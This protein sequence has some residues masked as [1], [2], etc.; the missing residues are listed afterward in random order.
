MQEHGARFIFNMK[1]KNPAELKHIVHKAMYSVDKKATAEMISKRANSVAYQKHVIQSKQ[2]KTMQNSK[3]INQSATLNGIGRHESS[4]VDR[5]VLTRKINQ[6]ELI[7]NQA[8]Y[9]DK[10]FDEGAGD[11]WMFHE[12][13][14][15]S[16]TSCS[17]CQKHKYT[18]I[19][20]E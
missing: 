12:G 6:P 8:P 11:K 7:F 3:I 9:L 5:F 15:N 19:F 2:S 16:M 20:Y 14:S 10:F 1:T 18:M 13:S 17:I 4:L